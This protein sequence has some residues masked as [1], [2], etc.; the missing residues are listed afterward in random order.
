MSAAQHE[1]VSVLFPDGRETEAA[2]PPPCFRDLNFDAIV[3]AV[4]SRRQGYPLEP[5]FWVPLRTVDEIAYR[6]EVFRDLEDEALRSALVEFSEQELRVR[7]YLELAHKQEF[8]LAKQH[9]FHDAAVRYTGAIAGLAEALGRAGAR[10]RGLSRLRDFLSGYTASPEFRQ[11]AEDTQDVL[12]RLDR[13]AYTVRIKG[14]RVT[15]DRFEDQP[16]YTAEIE[17]TFA[18][19]RHEP[20]EDHL[21]IPPDTGTMD[22]V[23]AEI[24]R[25]V[26]KLHPQEFAALDAFWHRHRDFVHPLVAR[27]EQEVQFYLAWQEQVE[28]LRGAGL[29][30]CLP[31]VSSES[32]ETEAEAAFDLALALKRGA[33]SP[34]VVPNDF[35][36][37]GPERILVVSGPN[38]G[39]KTTFARAF[40]QLHQLARLGVPVPARRAR[41]FL[42]DEIYTHF[43]R[44]EDVASLRGKLDDE[45]LRVQR[46]LGEAS[47]DSVAILNEI[48]SA[49]TLADAV[50]LGTEVLSRLIELDC[51]GVCVTFVDELAT[52]SEATVSMVAT[53]DPADPAIRTF[54]IV[55]RRADGRAY[56]SALAEK[57]GLSYERLRERSVS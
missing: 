11:L 4:A 25:R 54:E 22:L 41:L 47:G 44:E 12:E 55:R 7:R 37:H 52:L 16:D 3:E 27:F 32:K 5:F 15:V 23:E 51:L 46:I 50:V 24:A 33:D 6:H 42:A 57:Y 40:G 28:A 43:E 30:C 45:L 18:R 14:N 19:F 10:S 9:T 53:V 36:L 21:A 39:G 17:E 29:D 26:A 56:A 31:E 8:R 20:V 34:E 2:E 13:V 49:T 35:E 1:F 38:Q 48:F